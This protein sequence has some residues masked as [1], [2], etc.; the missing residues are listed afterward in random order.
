M[1]GAWLHPNHSSANSGQRPFRYGCIVLKHALQT[2]F[3]PPIVLQLFRYGMVGIG[4][5]F[6]TGSGYATGITYLDLDPNISL[7]ISYIFS[8][9]LAYALHSQWSF[10]GHGERDKIH[11]RSLRFLFTNLLAFFLN[12]SFVFFLVKIWKFSPLFPII[13]MIFLT[14]LLSFILNRK[15][16]FS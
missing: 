2:K 14:P 8:F 3:F 13:P 1:L 10:N 15:W 11:I 4:L 5:V 7:A 9:I 6:I 16:V 12:Q